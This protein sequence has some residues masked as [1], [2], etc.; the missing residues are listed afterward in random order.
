MS[1]EGE[2]GPTKAAQFSRWLRSPVAI[3]VLFFL[4]FASRMLGIGWGLP[5]PDNYFGFHPDEPIINLYVGQMDIGSGD[6]APGFYNY[7]TFYLTLCSVAHKVAGA[8]GGAVTEP[9]QA[10]GSDYF[11]GRV[12]TILAGS[13]LVVLVY[14]YALRSMRTTG[15]VFA[16]AA[17][18]VAPG[19]VVHGRFQTVDVT[20]AM[21]AFASLLCAQMALPSENG[22]QWNLMKAVLWAGAFAGLSAGTKYTGVLAIVGIAPVLW[23]VAADRSTKVKASLAGI[24]ALLLAFVISTPGIFIETETFRA[25]VAYEMQHTATGHGLVFLGTPGGV[26]YHII[27]LTEGYGLLLLGF[28]LAG[29]FFAVRSKNAHLAGPILFFLLTYIVIGRAEVKFLRYTLPLIPTLA[30]CFGYLVSNWHAKATIN[31]RIGIAFAFLAL[32]GVGPG[33]A[34]TAANYTAWM[35]SDDP[36]TTAAKYLRENANPD[37]TVGLVSPPWY[38]SPPYYPLAT[39]PRYV[40]AEAR[41]ESLATAPFRIVIAEGDW[42]LSLLDERPDYVVFSSFEADDLMRIQ[43]IPS[44]AKANQGL[45][46]NFS[47]FQSRMA[48]DY[49]LVHFDGNG[50]PTIHDMMYVQPR[51]W[52]YHRKAP[53][54]TPGMSSSTTS[55]SSEAQANTP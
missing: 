32:G 44:L 17:V 24:G 20:A 18:V 53:T 42:N 26:M 37:E 41:G 6:F 3:G 39:A 2:I 9:W 12:V 27:N 25:N 14:L 33:G 55:D 30:L 47:A 34:R 36:R 15:A 7:G 51:V 5:S 49:E 43:E 35:M 22:K 31:A 1:A 8:Y 48:E 40:S 50:G 28:S 16:A 21:L 46:A 45:V 29:M 54:S 23:I 10:I 52:I 11:A 13:A 38:Y 4:A 19:L